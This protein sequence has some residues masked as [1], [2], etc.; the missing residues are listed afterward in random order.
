M[1]VEM[2]ARSRWV[3]AGGGGQ[4]GGG[5]VPRPGGKEIC[6]FV[7]PRLCVSPRHAEGALRPVP[8]C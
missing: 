3:L 1:K 4:G 7:Y 8:L 5:G 2:H 6:L